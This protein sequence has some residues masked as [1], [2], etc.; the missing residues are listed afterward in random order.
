MQKEDIFPLLNENPVF[1]L[2]TM[3]NDQPRVRGMLLF[4]ADEKGII[5]HTA[6]TKDVFKQ[7]SVNPKVEMCFNCKSIQIRI[8]GVLEINTDP[9]LREEIFA[10]P[11]RKFLQAWKSM[12]IDNL[13]TV[14]V[15]KNG[16]ATTW[17]METN[18]S[19]KQ[20]IKLY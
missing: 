2:A 4:R 12:G 14:F 3:D 7:I 6:S 8:T 17:T 5:F 13:L 9:I 20:Y 11:S 1:H 18:F 15:L 16:V 19:K 10:H